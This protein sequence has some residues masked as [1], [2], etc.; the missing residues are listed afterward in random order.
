MSCNGC[1]GDSV[2]PQSLLSFSRTGVFL[3]GMVFLLATAGITKGE[4]MQSS[5]L[6]LIP[7]PKLSRFVFGGYE[8]DAAATVAHYNALFS[9]QTAESVI[10]F[11]E[12][13]GM[14]VV[15]SEN[16]NEISIMMERFVAVFYY[17]VGLSFVFEQG[18]FKKAE[19]WS[20]GVK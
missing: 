16:P 3:L 20:S 12:A 17:R 14:T 4:D 18:L 1:L 6:I 7:E 15:Y 19:I 2:V 13:A 8:L 11:L 10:R 9:G 5:D